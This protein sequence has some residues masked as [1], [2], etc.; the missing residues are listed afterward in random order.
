MLLTLVLHNIRSCYNVGA[1]LRTAEGLGV[2]KVTL[3]GYT[4]RYNDTRL[5][6]HLREKLNHELSKTALGAETLVPIYASDDIFSDLQNYRLDGWRI[7]GLE[8]HLHTDK[9]VYE[10]NDQN[11]RTRLGGKVVLILGEEVS[12]IDESL[13]DYIDT[14][15][16]IPMKGKK[17]SFNVSVAAAI[18]MAYLCL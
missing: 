14:F 10:I 11:L 12:G 6:P 15:L 9:P 18:A 8:N 4:P 13:Y 7:V 3:S 17:E 2:H 1:V 5:L 16:E